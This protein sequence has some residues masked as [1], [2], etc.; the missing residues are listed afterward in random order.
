MKD[1]KN[2]L[3]GIAL[4]SHLGI[5][6]LVPIFLCVYIGGRLDHRLSKEYYTIIFLALGIITAFRNAYFLTKGFYVK[7]KAKEDARLNHMHDFEIVNRSDKDKTRVDAEN[8]FA[9]WKE[10]KKKE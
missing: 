4:V 2:I 9:L 3:K 1:N 7:D 8:E 5:S 10:L 6:I